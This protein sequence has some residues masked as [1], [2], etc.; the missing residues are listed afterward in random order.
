MTEY[1]VEGFEVWMRNNRKY[2]ESL[3]A[4]RARVIRDARVRRIPWETLRS[5]DSSDLYYALYDRPHGSRSHRASIRSAVTSYE[6]Y[7][8]MKVRGGA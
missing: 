3:V 4:L 7:L 1:D 5:M 6:Q 2:N 8:D